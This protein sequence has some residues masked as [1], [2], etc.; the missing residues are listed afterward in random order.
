MRLEA[1]EKYEVLPNIWFNNDRRTEVITQETRAALE[2]LEKDSE[3][4]DEN[5]PEPNSAEWKEMLRKDARAG[6]RKKY[7]RKVFGKH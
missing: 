4:I 1:E 5:Y 2:R 7:A 6:Y 3:I